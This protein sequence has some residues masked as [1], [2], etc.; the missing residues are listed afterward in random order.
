MNG[1]LLNKNDVKTYLTES[2][3]GLM[4][5]EDIKAISFEDADSKC[6]SGYRVIGELV[7]VI[8]APEFNSSFNL[9]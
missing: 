1:N 6:P 9:N 2:L 4:C 8:E 7:E 5:G 3:S